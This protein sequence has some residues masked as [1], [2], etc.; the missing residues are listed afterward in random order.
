MKVYFSWRFFLIIFLF[1]FVSLRAMEVA[2]FTAGGT[3]A[4]GA[5]VC[6]L[7]KISSSR[8]N[9]N[10]RAFLAHQEKQ[11]SICIKEMLASAVARE[12][13]DKKDKDDYE[14]LSRSVV[15]LAFSIPEPELPQE[16]MRGLCGLCKWLKRETSRVGF[17]G[18]SFSNLKLKYEK[19][20]GRSIESW[21]EEMLKKNE[22]KKKPLD[23][24]DTMLCELIQK[25]D[26]YGERL[27]KG[28]MNFLSENSATWERNFLTVVRKRL[29]NGREYLR[30][31]NY[32]SQKI[33]GSGYVP[34][35]IKWADALKFIE[36]FSS[37]S[38]AD[39]ETKVIEAASSDA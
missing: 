8:A 9:E 17:A 27:K 13:K 19:P 31:I 34:I 5:V 23:I 25:V 15:E 35:E 6:C 3:L 37:S 26:L 16:S 33:D 2:A 11:E 24:C 28:D 4:L 29:V 1:N 7:K 21:L 20:N 39:A 22:S 30:K 38:D 36:I 18:I 12:Q 10:E 14:K 32:D